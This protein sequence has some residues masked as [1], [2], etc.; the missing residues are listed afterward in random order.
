MNFQ[1]IY[2]SVAAEE[3]WPDDLL[4]LVERARANNAPLGITGM[5][6]FHDNRFLQLLEGPEAEVRKCFERIKKDK[7]HAEVRVL[8]TDRTPERSFPDWTMGFE[9]L[10]EAWNLPRSWA[11]ILE[12]EVSPSA[13]SGHGA[14]AKD[15]LLTFVHGIGA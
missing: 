12:D 10:E 1:L 14:A 8:L 6:L 4:N 9:R 5:L 7:R 11:T 3:F 2:T 15:F 13:R